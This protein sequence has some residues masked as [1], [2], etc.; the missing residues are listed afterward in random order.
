[1]LSAHEEESAILNHWCQ[2]AR[3][4]THHD[5]FRVLVLVALVAVLGACES[6]LDSRQE[7]ADQVAQELA[8]AVE[9]PLE[10]LMEADS[11]AE[12]E[13]AHDKVSTVIEGTLNELDSLAGVKR[14]EPAGIFS[15]RKPDRSAARTS[16]AAV[17]V[18]SDDSDEG[19][20]ILAAIHSDG[21]VEAGVTPE[22]QAGGCVNADLQMFGTSP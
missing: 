17:V 15:G 7:V 9:E 6:H 19:Y 12:S 11:D 16:M 20:C 18:P 3:A 1:M 14:L 21:R 8:I 4:L 22:D 5:L 10:A 2:R 13:E